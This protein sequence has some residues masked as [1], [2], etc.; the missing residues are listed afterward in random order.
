MVASGWGCAKMNMFLHACIIYMYKSAHLDW[1]LI[2]AHGAFGVGGLMGPLLVYFV[3][4]WS[5]A[6][7]SAFMLMGIFVFSIM[8]SPEKL[9]ADHHSNTLQSPLNA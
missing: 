4:Y 8:V 6:I 9:V 3:V 7:L 1:Y 2:V 5:Y